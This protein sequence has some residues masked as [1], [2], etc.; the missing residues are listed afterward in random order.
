MQLFR[1]VADD[2]ARTTRSSPVEFR[3]EFPQKIHSLAAESN[4]LLDELT[5]SERFQA[6]V[7]K[8]ERRAGARNAT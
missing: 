5:S 2:V 8:Q 1:L 6:A 7:R 3:A 4:T